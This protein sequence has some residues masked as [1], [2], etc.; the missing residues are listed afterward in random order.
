MTS[1]EVGDAQQLAFVNVNWNDLT[2]LDLSSLT[3]LQRVNA[4]NNQ[5][6]TVDVSNDPNLTTVILTNNE[7]LND[8]RCEMDPM[9]RNVIGYSE[10]N[11]F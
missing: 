5:L 7:M 8:F 9:L 1:F 3:F 2:T 11:V 4:A 10:W 6:L